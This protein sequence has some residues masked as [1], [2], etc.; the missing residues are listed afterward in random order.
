MGGL[1]TGAT[2]GLG[3]SMET[4]YST[5]LDTLKSDPANPSALEVLTK[6]HPGNGTGLDGDALGAILAQAR[7]WHE[8][9]GDIVLCVQL[10]DI[11]LGWT[12]AGSARG[13]L[14][15]Q[16]ARL[17]HNELVHSADARVCLAEALETAPGHRSAV[18]LQKAIE[19][20]EADWQDVAKAKLH[21]A[22]AAG[23]RPAGAPS[24]ALAG[25]LFLKF[26][27]KSKEGEAFLRRALE[28][29]PR[30]KRA[31]VLLERLLREAGRA[32]DLVE[33]YDRRIGIAGNSEER[34]AAE[35]LAGAL[36]E[37][38]GRPER[39]FEHFRM[40]LA[41]SPSEPRALRWM[42]RT[43]DAGEK[44]ADLAKVYDNALR[45]TKRGPAEI[46]LLLPLANLL[47][48]KLAQIDQA[49]LY[50]RRI[51]K[52]L[53]VH[54]E[55]IDFYRD[56]HTSRNEIPQLLAH[57]A[58]AQ[59]G[60]NDSDKRILSASRWPSWRSSGPSR[61]RRPSTPGR[62]CSVC[63]RAC[64]RRSPPCGGSTPRPRSGTRS[65]SC[66]RTTSRRCPPPPSMRRW[67]A[68]WR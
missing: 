19:A 45:T 62:R 9:R 5:A 67:P 21:Q 47:W 6:L 65:S 35:S 2:E 48:K 31:D 1:D 4:E 37:Q 43:L 22:K 38:L 66:S 64:P 52:V 23:D 55:V 11:E 56:Y 36:A 16:K 13:E 17:L 57:L 51:K 59:K 29:D 20:E 44:W 25:E 27:P 8:E 32:E 53:P 15:T 34:A 26:R 30:Q 58:Q 24:W 7:A 3:F 60:E 42:V 49:E 63:G 68:T 18:D 61:W 33:I 14:L 50:Y 28:L 40:A 46:P 54:P 41:A 39:A 10:I 12:P